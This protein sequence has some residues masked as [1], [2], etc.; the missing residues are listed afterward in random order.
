MYEGDISTPEQM[1]ARRRLENLLYLVIVKPAQ[2]GREQTYKVRDLVRSGEDE[3]SKPD[4]VEYLQEHIQEQTRAETSHIRDGLEHRRGQGSGME[5]GEVHF[6]T[7]QDEKKKQ[8]MRL[9]NRS[10]QADKAATSVQKS[11]ASL[12]DEV[13]I[14]AF[15]HSFYSWCLRARQSLST[16]K[17]QPS[18]SCGVRANGICMTQRHF[19]NVSA[20]PSLRSS[21]SCLSVVDSVPAAKR[22]TLHS[23]RDAV[24]QQAADGK[25]FVFLY[26][27]RI[28][29]SWPLALD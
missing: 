13:P 12:A 9:K 18:I 26:F 16:W 23:L 25:P 24:R 11:L 21:S 4:L 28:D 29:K 1:T 15:V 27:S 17:V 14:C 19:E 22:G 2:P 5:V 10:F 6:L 7:Q 3:V 20:L 8:F